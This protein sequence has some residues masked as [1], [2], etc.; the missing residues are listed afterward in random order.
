MTVI[1]AGG[2]KFTRY[3]FNSRF[4]R[5]LDKLSP[6]LKQRT[7]EKIADLCKD[8]R[9]AGLAFEK[10]KGYRNPDLYSIHVTGNYKVSLEVRSEKDACIAILRRVAPHNQI[11]RAP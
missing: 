5:E 8:P 11:D 1:G 4:K 3:R 2:I 6:G 10:L 9:P 7:L